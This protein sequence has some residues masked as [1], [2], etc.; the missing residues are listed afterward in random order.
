MNA[1]IYTIIFIIGTVFGSFFTL[2][3]YRIPRK[4]D[5]THKHSF[6]PNCNHKLGFF[7]L[8]PVLS[9]LILRGKCKECGKHIR[10]RYFLLEILS[11]L[12]FLGLA[13]SIKF[14]IYTINIETIINIVPKSFW[15]NTIKGIKHPIKTIV[16]NNSILL[17]LLL[18]T[19]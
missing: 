12:T 18:K 11:G 8:I 10:I 9:Y 16:T 1:F 6:C 17:S 14:N 4:I 19:L 5:I 13:L 15:K 2:A 3:V 7:E